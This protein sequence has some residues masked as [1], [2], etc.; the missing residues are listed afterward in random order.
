MRTGQ[1]YKFLVA[2]CDGPTRVWVA[3]RC[4]S[5]FS[6]WRS[7]STLFLLPTWGREKQP[8]WSILR[9]FLSWASRPARETI[10]P[11]HNLLG[12]Y[13]GPTDL[14]EERESTIVPTSFPC[15]R[16]EISG[17]SLPIPLKKENLMKCLFFGHSPG[18]PH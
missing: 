11:E 17:S 4:P 2:Q 16:M 10:V 7:E 18:A 14:G 15:G 13:P 1:S 6:Q 9:A 3:S 12:F 5:R 8:F